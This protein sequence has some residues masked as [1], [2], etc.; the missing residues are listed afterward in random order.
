[1]EQVIE[2][3]KLSLEDIEEGRFHGGVG[4][5]KEKT[6]ARSGTVLREKKEAHDERV[7][8]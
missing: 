5:V 2:T 3:D 4:T 7:R 1:M 6:Q 8:E